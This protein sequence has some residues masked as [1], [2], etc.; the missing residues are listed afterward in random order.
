MYSLKI[1]RTKCIFFQIQKPKGKQDI[2]EE[3]L[4]VIKI[5]S[6]QVVESQKQYLLR[7]VLLT[8]YFRNSL[9]VGN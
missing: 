2:V 1:I 7:A 4:K 6:V 8:T 9:K 3:G 5:Q